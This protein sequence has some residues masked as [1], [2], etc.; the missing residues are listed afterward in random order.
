MLIDYLA[1]KEAA[2]VVLS[3]Y[4]NDAWGVPNIVLYEALMGSVHG[5]LNGSP[6]G[7]RD[8][9]TQTMQVLEVTEETAVEAAE[10]QSELRD[11]G[12]LADH[13]DALYAAVARQCGGSFATA[14]KT[15][16]REEVRAVLDVA[17][18]RPE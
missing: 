7:I 9:I 12:V 11:R 15:L 3:E 16:H 18:Y 2:R 5:H 14:K 6:A 10:L 8:A 17:A 13:P 4:R 1:G